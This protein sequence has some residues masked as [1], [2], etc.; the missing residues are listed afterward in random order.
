[1]GTYVQHAARLLADAGERV[2]VVAH[3]WDGAP[4]RRD[5]SVDGRLIVHRL[6]LDDAPA[7]AELSGP[8]ASYAPLVAA[9]L[10]AS[11]YP[12]QAFAWQ[13]ARLVEQL[14][15]DE[16]IDV[17]E[18][19]EW[20]APLAYFQLRR[21]AGL[22]PSVRP[23]C[24]VHVHSPTERI[25]AANGWDTAVAD[26]A[27]AAALEAYSIQT[28]DAVLCP[29]R[30]IADET[31]A[32]YGLDP[33]RVT[34]V[35][36]PRGDT[37]LVERSSEV[38]A[39]PTVCHVGRLEPRKGVV[40]WAQAIAAVAPAHPAARF[41]FI[42]G[43]TPMAVTG[44]T[45]VGDVMRRH[46][47][48]AVRRQVRFHGSVDRAGVAALLGHASAAVVPSRW[49]NFPYSCIEAMS[50]GLP[51]LASPHGGMRELVVDGE[52]GWIA[53]DATPEALAR[54]LA[55]VLAVSGE[56]KQ[57]MGRSAAATVRRVCDSASV[58]GQHLAWKSGL[59]AR[60]I[61]VVHAS[62]PSRPADDARAPAA[63]DRVAWPVIAC[64]PDG[65][66]AALDAARHAVA[67][68][69]SGVVLTEAGA[70]V[71]GGALDGVLAWM[72]REPA[73]GLVSGW[74]LDDGSPA[75]LV[76]PPVLARPLVLESGAAS[77]AVLVR[78]EVVR[79]CPAASRLALFDAA[80]ASGW[81]SALWPGVLARGTGLG[82]VR[83]RRRYSSMA[84]AVQRLHMPVLQ[85]LRECSAEDR[86]RFV[87]DGLKHPG[88]SVRWVA[89]RAAR[90]LRAG[91]RQG[92]AEPPPSSSRR[93][94]QVS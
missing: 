51:V 71:D 16:P 80:A 14:V 72:D 90:V 39:S 12:T 29:S 68:G 58:V 38:W 65:E 91:A 86:R 64:S 10:L 31:I 87:A 76:L 21:A 74:T 88:R 34:V 46:L 93:P 25:F 18:A 6:A 92:P 19:Q 15:V 54:A 85:W 94:P 23:P 32:R 8:H 89:D 43:D 79:A 36:Y 82:G 70:T 63:S 50:T 7:P 77:P 69:A 84:L 53:A 56:A 75:R 57:A 78:A 22:G 62:R 17:I 33:G 83:P 1:M 4:R 37:P 20:E 60:P 48:R 47:P 30:F 13:A 9:A 35:P 26:F 67:G 28:A 49:E 11:P 41:D 55:R 45:T 5:V 40:E 44:G 52:S 73:L 24:V 81:S 3:R 59:S 27:P 42:G 2:H 66:S 61:P